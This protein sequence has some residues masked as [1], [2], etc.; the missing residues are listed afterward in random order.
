MTPDLEILP[1]RREELTPLLEFQ[2]T[3]Y[4]SEAILLDDFRIPPM[5]QTLEQM[6]EEFERGVFLKAVHADFPERFIGSVRGFPEEGTLKIGKLMVDPD[7]RGRGIGSYLLG[8]LEGRFP[9]FR[10]ELFTSVKSEGNLRLYRSRGYREFKR[11]AV[12]PGLE[13]VWLEK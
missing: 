6:E 13:L 2:K 12:S 4:R 10:Y 9:G 7:H 11:V 1:V 5:I 3:C 8:T